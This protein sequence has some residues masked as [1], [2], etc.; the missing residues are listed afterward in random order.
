MKILF[1]IILGFVAFIIACS[2]SPASFIKKVCLQNIS[3]IDYFQLSL[4]EGYNSMYPALKLGEKAY[5]TKVNSS[6]DV[7]VN[8][9][10]FF[11]VPKEYGCYVLH[12]IVSIKDGKYITKGD[13][14]KYEDNFDTTI[15]KIHYKVTY[16]K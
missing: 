12:R 1:I 14:N 15:L 16:I 13:N 5:L 6:N 8:D 11:E 9:I 3:N 7:K 10:I 4:E 2:S